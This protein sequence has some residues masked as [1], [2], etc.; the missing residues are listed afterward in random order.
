MLVTPDTELMREE[1]QGQGQVR[2]R[3]EGALQIEQAGS[4]YTRLMALS[5]RADVQRV[6]LDLTGLKRLDSSGIAVISLGVELMESVSKRLTVE[7]ASTSHQE[8]LAMMP[9]KM[10][11]PP[12]QAPEG[13][14]AQLGGW[15]MSTGQQLA[16]YTLLTAD[17]IRAGWQALARG[18]RPPR[19]AVA[20]QSVAVGVNALPIVALLSLLLGLIMAFQSAYQLQQFGA[21]IF[22]ANL[23]GISMA[24]EFGPMMTAIILAG[25]SGSAMAAELGTMQVQEEIDALRTMG[26]EPVRFLVLPRLIAILLMGPML[27]LMADL[28]GIFGGFL[29]GTLYMDLSV[30]SYVNQTLIAVKFSDFAHGIA[31]SAVFAWIIGTIGCYCG[32]TIE[33]GA[34]GVG[35]ATTQAVVMSIFMIIVADSVFATI[36]TL[37]R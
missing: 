32:M 18:Q 30:E 26:L 19:G 25:R 10:G 24:R 36:L 5:Q 21:N 34:S 4:L 20:Q 33:G 14:W 28:I 27:T 8:A 16:R 6:T 22:V 9:S 1:P 23:V 3:L 12:A 37:T 17:A 7:G 11:Q 15:G 29:I 35:R 2:L 13:L 31:K